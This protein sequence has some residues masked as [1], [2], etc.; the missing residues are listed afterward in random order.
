M[1]YFRYN[2]RNCYYEELG[3]GTPLCLLH[4]NTASSN[5]F[6]DIAAQ[7]ADDYRVILI[8]FLGH[9][10]S[11]RVSA[12][13][14]DLWF[15]EACQVITLLREQGLGPAHLIGSSG[16]AIVAINVALE[17]PELVGRVIADSFEGEKP[18]DAFTQTI[19][20]SRED[21]KQEESSVAFYHMMHGA[22][23]EAVVDNDTDA[24]AAHAKS[25]GDFYH[26]P[27][28]RLRPDIL[29]T[30]SLEDEF[31]AYVGKSYFKDTFEAMLQ[32]IGH[33][34]YHLFKHGGHP[35]M[36]SNPEEFTVL[37]KQ[38]LKHGTLF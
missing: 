32:K 37:S 15:D 25:I 19:I 30:G 31:T 2:G 14:A 26:T 10:Q 34:V 16:G 35:A 20:Q 21:S 11:D 8:D 22:D 4:G 23:W 6:L 17:A 29:M 27:L 5:M 38:F 7:Y 13:P 18:L 36:L 33:G 24:I 12:F 3:S 9:G 28:C 1:A